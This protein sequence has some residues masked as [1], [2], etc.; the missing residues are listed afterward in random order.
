MVQPLAGGLHRGEDHGRRHQD[1]DRGEQPHYHRARPGPEDGQPGRGQAQVQGE[2]AGG[3]RGAD[4]QAGPAAGAAGAARHGA[5]HG[6]GAGGGGQRPHQ[7]PLH[8]IT[9]VYFPFNNS[10][11]RRRARIHTYAISYKVSATHIV[12]YHL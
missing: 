7:L 12:H 11:G 2:P 3:D 8:P 10:V 9:V 1:D 4:G 5:H 6:G